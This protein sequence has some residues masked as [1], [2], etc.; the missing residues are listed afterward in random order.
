M[1]FFVYLLFFLLMVTLKIKS[2]NCFCSNLK[3]FNLSFIP[4]DLMGFYRPITYI[5]IGWIFFFGGGAG[6][7]VKYD[8][9]LF[10][11]KI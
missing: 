9:F 8:M 5:Y 2:L 11:Y 10:Q 1:Y 3:N 6:F 7:G 4:L